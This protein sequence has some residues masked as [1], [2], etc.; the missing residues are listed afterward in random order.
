MKNQA[1]KASKPQ[2]ANGELIGSERLTYTVKDTVT[3]KGKD[4]PKTQS[5]Q[6]TLEGIVRKGN[7]L[8]VC[9]IATPSF[10]AT[11]RRKGL[12]RIDCF[13]A[14]QSNQARSLAL[15]KEHPTTLIVKAA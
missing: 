6:I 14:V 1:G 13:K 11:A 5:N 12:L 7:H 15:T 2:F 4:T 8:S 9:N 10:V 3:V